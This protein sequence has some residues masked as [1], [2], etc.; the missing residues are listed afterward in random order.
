MRRAHAHSPVFF[1][2]SAT[3]APAGFGMLRTDPATL[4]SRVAERSQI[5][6]ATPPDAAEA[7]NQ[8]VMFVRQPADEVNVF[9]GKVK[10]PFVGDPSA[11]AILAYPD[12]LSCCSV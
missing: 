4:M 3:L 7:R 9:F 8:A 5:I 11:V 1:R 6:T 10:M 2:N 12:P